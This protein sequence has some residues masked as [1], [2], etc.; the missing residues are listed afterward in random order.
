MVEDKDLTDFMSDN[1]PTG[2][3]S[4]LDA[5]REQI[6]TLKTKGYSG[7]DIQRFLKEKKS[8]VV[9]LSNLNNYIKNVRSKIEKQESSFSDNTLKKN[10]KSTK[11]QKNEQISKETIAPN[12]P[13]IWTNRTSKDLI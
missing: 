2:K 9:S 4:K 7:K 12:K 10:N 3:Q 6:I 5:Y 8:V 1:F 11:T 13:K